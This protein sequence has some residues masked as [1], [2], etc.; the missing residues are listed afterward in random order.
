MDMNN[1]LNINM[2]IWF[3]TFKNEFIDKVASFRVHGY[4]IVDLDLLFYLLSYMK[5]VLF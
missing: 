1:F 3:Y 2:G 4:P 5:A